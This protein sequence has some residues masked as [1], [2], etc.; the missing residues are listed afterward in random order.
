MGFGF[1]VRTVFARLDA[2]PTLVADLE[3]LS[4]RDLVAAEED[5]G[6]SA[7]RLPLRALPLPV[8]VV[9]DATALF[10]PDDFFGATILMIGRFL[11]LVKNV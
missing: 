9:R 2:M 4:L 8:V 7:L 1:G 3:G 11:R 6:S 5:A 10:V